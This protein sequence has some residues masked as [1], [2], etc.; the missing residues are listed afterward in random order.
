MVGLAA[1]RSFPLGSGGKTSVWEC[2]TCQQ[3]C[4]ETCDIRVEAGRSVHN[5]LPHSQPIACLR[6]S[7]W[8]LAVQEAVL[9]R[10]CF[11]LLISVKLN[12]NG[13]CRHVALRWQVSA[14]CILHVWSAWTLLLSLA[15]CCEA[16]VD[17]RSEDELSLEQPSAAAE[18]APAAAKAAAPKA[19]KA[20]AKKGSKPS[21]RSTYDGL[22]CMIC[23][24][25]PSLKKN[26]FCAA[27]KTDV[28][29]AKKDAKAQNWLEKYE[30]ARGTPAVFRRLI[31]DFQQE[32]PS[33]GSDRKRPT[34]SR[35]RAQEVVSKEH[36]ADE[37]V[38]F[39]KMD[40]FGFESF[41]K[42]KGLNASEIDAKWKS[43]IAAE[44]AYDLAGEN[45]DYPERLLVKV[46]E[47]VDA[48]QRSRRATEV[49][50]ETAQD[51][52]LL[53]DDAAVSLL[54]GTNLNWD[55]DA[56]GEVAAKPLLPRP[57]GGAS[58]EVE[59]GRP[60]RSKKLFQTL[61]SLGCGV[62][63]SSGASTTKRWQVSSRPKTRSSLTF[64]V[65]DLW[66]LLGS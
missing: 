19:K 55:E 3:A 35:A 59:A 48:K 28:G 26:P 15:A 21:G 18:P 49:V 56:F 64:P 30:S 29:A 37:G 53:E 11:G 47:Y 24:K 36:V 62:T 7:G 31:L 34:Y 65:E 13:G 52:K 54:K 42:S 25:A 2:S 14:L 33:A 6:L 10:G 51:K 20:K 17:V 41:Y 60:V 1:D 39:M 22:T 45:K 44:G 43:R 12:W 16:M 57:S 5:S 58:L 38:R 46:E 66:K 61:Q 50:K 23:E 40:W 4:A 9:G 27:C 8:Q 63:K 32:C